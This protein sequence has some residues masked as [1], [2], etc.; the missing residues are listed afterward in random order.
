MISKLSELEDKRNKDLEMLVLLVLGKANGELSVLHLQKII[1]TIWRFHPEVRKLLDFEPH[2]KGPYSEDLNEILREPTLLKD[3]WEYIPPKKSS[4]SEK[5]K[6]G[7]IKLTK[8]GYRKYEKMMHILEQKS[9]ED[10]NIL[11][12]LGAV[13][14]VTKLYSKLEWDELLLL[15]YTDE[16]NKEFIEKSELSKEIL[17]KSDRIINKLIAK[18]IYPEELKENLTKRVKS[19]WWI[20]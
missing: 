11:N 17:K 20:K 1:Y 15:L 10:E 7:Y 8:E 13:D 16:N 3:C 9:K 5:I 6:G 18:E 14:L 4:K 2:I 19:A 12:L